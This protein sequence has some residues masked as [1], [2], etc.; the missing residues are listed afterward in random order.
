MATPIT[1]CTKLSAATAPT[2]STLA[3]LHKQLN[4]YAAGITSS[5]GGGDHGHLA[6]VY[7]DA[8]YLALT[9]VAFIAPVHPGPTPIPGATGPIITENNRLHAA[10]IAEHKIYKDTQATI[11]Q[12]ILAAVPLTF[13][14]ELEDNELGF[15]TVTP[16]VILQHLDTN[17]GKVTH[18]DLSKNKSRMNKPWSGDQPIEDLWTQIATAKAYAATHNPI[19]EADTVMA[20][21]D[22]LQ[23]SGL[24]KDDLKS[25]RSKPIADQNWA[26][27]KEHFNQANSDR[28]QVQTV[29]GA[30]YSAKT[31]PTKENKA[32][33]DELKEFKNWKYCWS[34]GLNKSHSSKHCG[35]PLEGHVKEATLNNTHDGNR[36]ILVPSAGRVNGPRRPPPRQAVV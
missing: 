27:L 36:I 13:I 28:L 17:Y 4:T 1:E 16:Q 20:A 21:T 24:F 18:A 9:Q 7:S 23:N 32:N 5:R 34:H 31:E 12:M 33:Y 14:G 22:N 8:K 10:A 11:K 15:A 26:N 30:G 29:G 3:I 2:H 6:L 25:W 35:Q 19:S